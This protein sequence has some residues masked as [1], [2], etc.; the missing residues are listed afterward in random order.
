MIIMMCNRRNHLITAVAL[1][2]RIVP[3]NIALIRLAP[4]RNPHLLHTGVFQPSDY[5][6]KAAVSP[7]GNYFYCVNLWL[8]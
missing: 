4:D 5:N 2:L 1:L 3:D 8:C 7:V 6:V